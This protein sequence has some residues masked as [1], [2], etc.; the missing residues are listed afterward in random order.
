MIAPKVKSSLYL[1]PE[2]YKKAAAYKR[3]T[4]LSIN[5]I[6]VLALEEYFQEPQRR[7]LLSRHLEEFQKQ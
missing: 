4:S 3:A 2:L 1:N 5:T 7:E 6:C